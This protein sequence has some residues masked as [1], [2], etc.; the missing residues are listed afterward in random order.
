MDVFVAR[1]LRF[2][3]RVSRAAEAVVW[4][5]VQSQYY[6][7][8][9]GTKGGCMITDDIC[10]LCYTKDDIISTNEIKNNRE[11]GRKIPLLI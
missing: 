11:M 1:R 4:S 10:T 9:A 6:N 3:R 8:K 2:K 5:L 7:P